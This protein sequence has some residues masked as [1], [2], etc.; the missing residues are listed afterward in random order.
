MLM[1]ML[2]DHDY[3]DRY[4]HNGDTENYMPTYSIQKSVDYGIHVP[5]QS[6]DFF[7]IVEF[8]LAEHL[9]TIYDD[10]FDAHTGR[11]K[12]FLNIE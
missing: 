11:A 10:T 3:I 1:E 7:P 5:E 6:P 12:T 9:I 2:S 8:T 4:P